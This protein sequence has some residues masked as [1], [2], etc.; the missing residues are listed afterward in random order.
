[1]T[2]E[3]QLAQGPPAI[4]APLFSATLR[5][6][7]SLGPTGFLVLMGILSG[8]CFVTGLAFAWMGAWPVLGFFGLDVLIVYLSFKLSYRSGRLYEVVDVDREQLTLT[9]VHPNG[10]CE[11]YGFSSYWVRV[12]LQTAQDGRSDLRLGSHGRSISVGRFLTNEERDSFAAALD[13]ALREAKG[14]T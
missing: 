10:R 6:N 1:M 5:P 8:V 3:Q 13:V 2:D 4:A 11:R 7:R 12:S 9:R 14:G